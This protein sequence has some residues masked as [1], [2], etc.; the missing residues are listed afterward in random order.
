MLLSVA[1][2]NRHTYTFA[3]NFIKKLAQQKK[4][5]VVTFFRRETFDIPATELTYL[6]FI[7]LPHFLQN[8]SF[9]IHVPRVSSKFNDI[10]KLISEK[11]F[12]ITK[13]VKE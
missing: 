1:L 11:I 4:N 10:I 12:S 9:Q 2:N 13:A 7:E 3:K 5:L 8:F 6:N